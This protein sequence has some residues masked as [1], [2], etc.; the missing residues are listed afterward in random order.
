MCEF[1]SLDRCAAYEAARGACEAIR[2]AA[3]AWPDPLAGEARRAAESAVA[4]IAEGLGHDHGS[5]ARRRCLRAALATALE[6][7]ALC[8]VA[9]ALGEASPPGDRALR[10]AGRSVAML[11][12]FFHATASPFVEDPAPGAA[13]KM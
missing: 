9:R 11:G 5:A 7:A 8:D 4:W 3:A 13:T 1:E 12:L 2:G 10:L 6:L